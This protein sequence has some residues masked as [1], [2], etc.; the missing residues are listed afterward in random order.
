MKPSI[1]TLI[2]TLSL[3]A[4]TNSG[5]TSKHKDQSN[6]ASF[7]KNPLDSQ[8]ENKDKTNPLFVSNNPSVPKENGDNE[9][10][11][12]ID[13]GNVIMISA[14]QMSPFK[15]VKF[16]GCM[17]NLVLEEDKSLTN[18][19]IYFATHDTRFKT[20]EGFSVGTKFSSLSK[21][22]QNKL[23]KEPGWA[24]YCELPSGW[25]LG[26]CEG[27]SCTDNSPKENSEVKW[28]FERK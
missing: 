3:I 4:C 23:V 9:L 15:K 14:G 24:Y 22:L 2:L 19:T 17:F 12:N 8:N 5:Q 1:I 7:T 21:T 18:D 20:P 13:F 26:F 16:K 11:G 27:T 10:L 6:P 25:N 28:V